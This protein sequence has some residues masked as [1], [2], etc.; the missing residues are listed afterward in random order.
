MEW[1]P[2]AVV[3]GQSG[4][5]FVVVDFINRGSFGNVYRV[6]RLEDGLEFALKTVS[7]RDIDVLGLR[8]LLNEGRLAPQI[9]DPNVI[10][11]YHFHGHAGRKNPL[12]PKSTDRDAG[13]GP[14]MI[15]DLADG[16]LQDLLDARKA[17]AAPFKT[18]NLPTMFRQLASAM[19]AINTK[20][21][22]RDIRPANIL[23]H[24]GR[25]KVSDFGLAKPVGVR[26]STRD[27]L[28]VKCRPPEAWGTGAD[29]VAMDMYA[30]GLVFYE[31]ATL[32]HPYSPDDRTDP[33]AAWRLAHLFGAVAPADR[34]NRRLP[35][36]LSRLIAKMMAK[37]PEDR[38]ASW[39]EVL[40]RLQPLVET[41]LTRPAPSPSAARAVTP[42]SLLWR[43]APCLT[44]VG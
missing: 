12:Q 2:G 27:N 30:M 17:A 4:Q 34:V 28:H 21:I 18:V 36:D 41:R 37:R 22:H 39:D 1:Q 44:T 5:E 43:P 40:T 24:R 31:M 16:T 20:V 14:Y 42:G 3:R 19:K 15:M 9:D 26:S 38:W 6:R 7:G 23:I 8:A 10:R 13:P 35:R 25:L 32:R 11:A 29:T 33:I